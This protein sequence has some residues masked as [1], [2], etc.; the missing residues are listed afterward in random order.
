MFVLKERVTGNIVTYCMK[1]EKAR[2]LLKDYEAEDKK[3]DIYTEDFYEV[4]KANLQL[5]RKA[6]NMSQS[7]LAETAGVPLDTIRKYEQG[8]KDINKAQG[9]T[10]YKLA[11]ALDC[12]MEDLLNI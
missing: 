12:N 2:E 4:V 8:S 11:K 3:Q 1:E 10:L 6:K 7:K 5:I 9:M